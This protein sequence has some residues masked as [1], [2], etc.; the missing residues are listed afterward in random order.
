[1]VGDDLH[2]PEVQKMH[3]LKVTFTGEPAESIANISM[4][5]D[6]FE[7]A[8]K[9]LLSPYDNNRILVNGHL[10][11]LFNLPVM[12]SEG[13]SELCSLLN[14]F[15]EAVGA[16]ASWKCPTDKWVDF[17]VYMLIQ[18]LNTT[19]RKSWEDS[20]RASTTQPMYDTLHIFL[21][22]KVT[23][24]Q[25]QQQNLQKGTLTHAYN[26]ASKSRN[27]SFCSGQR[28]VTVC[29][30][31]RSKIVKERRDVVRENGLCF[32]CLGKYYIKLC[33]SNKQCH[34][35][36]YSPIDNS[37]ALSSS[38]SQSWVCWVRGRPW[39]LHDPPGGSSS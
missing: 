11:K 7:R 12:S 18:R 29:T 28:M 22:G 15:I 9:S 36:L 8:W 23:T 35:M 34:T 31:F 2:L 1:M 32:N 16:L 20:L 33:G 30:N 19:T 37:L 17:L 25:Q 38:C 10:T 24:R 14:D 4:K 21:A 39:I 5:A 6:N 13:I 27:C 3:Y 26:A